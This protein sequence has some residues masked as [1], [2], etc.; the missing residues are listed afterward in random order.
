MEI[1]RTP[2]AIRAF[3]RGQKSAGRKVGFVPTMGSLHKGHLSL[4]NLA[5]EECDTVVMSVF[6][7]PKQFNVTSDFETYPRDADS[8]FRLASSAGVAAVYAPSVG[9]M[10]PSGFDTVVHIDRT[11][12]PLEGAGRPG[13]FDGVAT[14]VTKLFAAVEPDVAVFGRKDY[15]QLAIV[16]RL[17]TDLDLPVR[18]IG[19]ETVREVD[20]LAMSSRNSRLSPQDRLAAPIVKRSLDEA[21]RT[22]ARTLEPGS[23]RAVFETMISGEPR[24]RLEYVSVA[25]AVTLQELEG[26]DATAVISCAVWFD[27]V[28]LIDNVVVGL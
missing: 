3:S 7:N 2:D 5:R 20:G 10:Y 13:H 25:D 12:A 8:D 4:V 21:A 15:Q 24:A 27:D 1:L 22:L 28:R 14:V 18:I 6:V 16:R 17:V 23:A 11:A 19:A 9:V 26:F